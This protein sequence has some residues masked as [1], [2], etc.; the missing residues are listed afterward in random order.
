MNKN[1]FFLKITWFILFFGLTLMQHQAAAQGNKK[2]NKDFFNIKAPAIEYSALDT[3]Q[4]LFE[5]EFSEESEAN[6]STDFLPEKNLSIVS[7]DT[8]TIGEGELS[9]VEVS[10][11]L[12]VDSMWITI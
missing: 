11:Q 4:V 12:S 9:I 5:E 1:I 8:S 7:E 6:Q 2:K 3:S 10:E